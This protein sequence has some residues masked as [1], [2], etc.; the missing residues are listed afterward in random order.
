MVDLFFIGLGCGLF[1][2]FFHTCCMPGMI[3]GEIYTFVNK[4]LSERPTSFYYANAYNKKGRLLRATLL[5]LPWIWKP[6]GGCL[7]CFNFWLTLAVFFTLNENIENQSIIKTVATLF[8][9][10]G[11]SFGI[12]KGLFVRFF[13]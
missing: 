11:F 12:V 3:F 2:L 5:F 4:W 13:G 1:S 9:V 8:L 7:L 6:L 10:E